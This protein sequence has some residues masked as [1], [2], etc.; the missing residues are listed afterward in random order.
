MT[1]AVLPKHQPGWGTLEPPAVVD[2][3]CGELRPAGAVTVSGTPVTR[4]FAD[5]KGDRVRVFTISRG[6]CA[7]S[8]EA[9]LAIPDAGN[10]P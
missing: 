7:E 5:R 2:L 10:D 8:S 1:C 4:A 6:I 9:S 3:G